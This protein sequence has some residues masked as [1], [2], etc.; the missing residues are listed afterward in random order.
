MKAKKSI[1][2]PKTRAKNAYELLK[3]IR[4]IIL[5]QPKR[6]AQTEILIHGRPGSV[7]S[8]HTWRDL[9]IPPCGTVGCRAGWIVELTRAGGTANVGIIDRAAQILGFGTAREI[10]EFFAGSAAEGEPG[11]REH[12]RSGAKGITAFMK[13]HKARLLATRIGR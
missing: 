2:L 9:I 13:E 3:E 6:Y 1:R 12:A 4:T 11:T 10:G 7:F 8:T 5:A